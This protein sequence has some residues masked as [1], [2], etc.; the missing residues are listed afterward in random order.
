MDTE[1]VAKTNSISLCVFT[2][3]NLGVMSSKK[4]IQRTIWR[5]RGKKIAA[6]L[7]L[8]VAVMLAGVVLLAA[9]LLARRYY[10]R[11]DVSERRYYALSDKTVKMLAGL[12]A[13]IEIVSFFQKSDELFEDVRN[14]L[15]EYNYE[16]DKNPDLDLRVRIVDPDRDLAKATRLAREYNVKRANIVVFFSEGRRMCLEADDI[17]EYAFV[18][19]DNRQPEKIRAGFGGEQAFSSAIL[20][21]VKARKPV[22]YFLEGHGEH[23]IKDY[24]RQSGYSR[25][26]KMIWRDNM[27]ARPLV[28][29]REREIPEDCSVL[30]IA[31]PDRR[32]PE[33]EID[34]ISRYLEQSG[35]V[36]VMVDPATVT[37]FEK[38]LSQWG[39]KLRSDV[40]V[41]PTQTLTGVEL[42]VT[43]YGQHPVVSGLSRIQTAFYMPRSVEP[44][45]PEMTSGSALSD[46]PRVSILV[47]CSEE[48]WAEL[49][50][51]ESPAR[52]DSKVDRPG[53]VSI[54]VAAERGSVADIDLGVKPT[55]MVVLGDSSFVSNGW[56]EKGH[57][58]E[59]FLLSALNWLSERE[60]LLAIGPKPPYELRLDMNR[61]Q[62][63][64]AFFMVVLV[65]PAIVAFAG[66]LVWI[67]R[68]R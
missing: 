39:V 30:V 29:S 54:A 66:V 51:N 35:R 32:I 37:G 21:L 49:N 31:G 8:G 68:R 4:D 17:D 60:S 45:E 13:E 5:L 48:G 46:K 40:V 15:A 12:D 11:W 64:A 23:S 50:L 67:R 56:L 24:G 7:N 34:L 1:K 6:G 25:I 58:N 38:L 63:R 52:F 22:V 44:A 2:D 14:L 53:P 20:S 27:D 18:S 9:N 59:S 65:I 42:V 62:L 41:D 33:F 36:L 3:W 55:R 61:N 10:R 16:A 57:G 28:I 43:E 26:A 19:G 47:S